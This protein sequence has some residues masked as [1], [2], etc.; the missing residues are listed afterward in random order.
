MK[1]KSLC[2]ALLGVFC[3]CVC[4]H[5]L[6]AQSNSQ[7]AKLLA[8]LDDQWSA[9]AAAKN[10]D[11]VVSFY[12]ADAVVYPPN[13]PVATNASDIRGVWARYFAA[14]G[15]QI[16]WK[17]TASSA[18]GKTGW[19]AGTYQDSLIGADGK[20]VVEKGKYLCVWQKGADGKWRAIRDMWNADSR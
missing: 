7:G 2:L 10:L 13:E 3:T 8:A 20:Q 18:Q 12:A 1:T 6:F 14:P 19:T 17:T 4:P 16:S 15:F 9:A 11:K 5:G